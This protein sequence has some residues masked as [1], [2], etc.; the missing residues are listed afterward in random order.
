MD[1]RAP[2]PTLLSQALVAYIIELDNE[3]EH[4]MPHRTT[5]HGR[6]P[7]T[8]R[9][10]WLT[11][12]A[13]WST[14]MRFVGE[15]GLRV[16]DRATMARTRTNLAGLR[17][18]GYITLERDPADWRVTPPEADLIIHA[19]AAGRQATEIWRE[20]F[21]VIELRWRQRFGATHVDALRD[22]LSS[23]S[24][25]LDMDVPDCL[26]ILGHGLSTRDGVSDVEPH[27]PGDDATAEAP[28]DVTL[29]RLLSRALLAFALI[30][31]GESDSD[32]ALAVGS[33]VLRVLDDNPTRLRD[34]PHRSGVSKEAIAMALG[35]L[36]RQGITE[37]GAAADGGRF[38]TVRLTELGLHT[39]D[40]YLDRL[41]TVEQSFRKRLGAEAVDAVRVAL[42][43]IVGDPATEN[44]PLMA[45]VKPYE[46]GWRAAV[47]QPATLPHYPM[48]LHRGG[49]PDGS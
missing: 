10:P 24:A 45:A 21:D 15:E 2:L 41:G 31:E 36:E 1:G 23:L 42:Q 13:M 14:C 25:R 22:A 43:D 26:P 35:L 33:N 29:Y 47:R 5:D 4:R 17:R 49:Y 30:F 28:E 44:S 9:G 27:R 40:A 7:G 37:V 12:V 32:V 6:S 34:L 19:T 18:W 11:S 38:K 8:A 46:D 39:R 3:F 20:V 16:H 48:I